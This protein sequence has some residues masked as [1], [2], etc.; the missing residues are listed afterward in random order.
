[1][2]DWKDHDPS[3][4]TEQGD[5]LGFARGCLWSLAVSA[6]MWILL[7]WWLWR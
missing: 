6:L 3:Q 1:M 5:K 4:K 7:I 2:N